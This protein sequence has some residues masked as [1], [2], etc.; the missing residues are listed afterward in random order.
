[1]RV[2]DVL[3]KVVN[4]QPNALAVMVRHADFD[5]QNLRPPYDMVP[6]KEVLQIVGDVYDMADSLESEG[7]VFADMILSF[8]D[9][10]VVSRKINDGAVVVLT[11][12]LARPQLIKLQVGL[13]LYTRALEKAL[14]H[15]NS[16]EDGPAPE[17]IEPKAVQPEAAPE[18]KAAEPAPEPEKPKKKPR[19]YRGVA[20]YD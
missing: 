20:Y 9:H 11:Q 6:A 3:E 7:Y 15:E 1:M 19:F 17:V 13:G 12:A 18:P 4:D 5:Y 2:K 10:N 8:G 14:E 16:A